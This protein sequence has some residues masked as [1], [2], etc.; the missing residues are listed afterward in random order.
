MIFKPRP[1]FLT[2]SADNQTPSAEAQNTR[3]G[4]KAILSEIAVYL[5]KRYVVG[6]WLVWNVNRK[7]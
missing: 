2:P 1:S 6:A 4:E 5:R 3:D 7:S